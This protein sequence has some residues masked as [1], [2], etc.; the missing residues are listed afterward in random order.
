MSFPPSINRSIDNDAEKG[1]Q[2]IL[3][4]C[5]LSDNKLQK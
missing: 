1:K 5:F 4:K 2:N 3:E